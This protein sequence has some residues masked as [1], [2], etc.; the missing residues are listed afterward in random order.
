MSRILLLLQLVALVAALC[1]TSV[2][3]HILTND[4]NP[5]GNTA[6]SFPGDV[7]LH[8]GGKG[9]GGGYL[10][11]T[12]T[13][14]SSNAHCVFVADTGSDDIASFVAPAY[15]LVGRFSNPALNFS[16]NGL[17]GSI[18][19][20]PNSKFLYGGYSGS[21]NIGAWA[22]NSNCSLTFIAAYVPSIGADFF[23]PLAVTPNGMSLI[24]SAP[25]LEAAEVFRINANGT[26]TDLNSVSWAGVGMCPTV[27]CFP[28][29][30]DIT[31]DSKVAVFGNGTLNLPSALS[32]AIGAGGLSNPQFWDLSNSA[33][34][35][36]DEVP[37]FSRPGASGNGFLYF[38]MS[39]FGPGAP[40]GEVTA[41]FTEFPLNIVV[42]N[43]TTISTPDGLQG[44]IRSHGNL[45]YVA[46]YPNT[47]D[48]FKINS[49]GSL[50]FINPTSD[51]QGVALL[52]LSVYPNT[53]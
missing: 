40:G 26:L 13:A 15:G 32:A 22:V 53:R 25:D 35:Q 39:G 8:T 24:V 51:P 45:M 12:G 28:S 18:A 19:L 52:S 43:S 7:V 21:S 16:A 10:A 3:Q 34:V 9:L 4:D 6:T 31:A 38:G 48:T 46:V 49:N 36:N 14:I 23:S 50:T 37:W 29:G 2:A 47:I 1:S 44:A 41:K 20:A 33:G 42:V 11:N 30:I 17:G 5:S 27:G